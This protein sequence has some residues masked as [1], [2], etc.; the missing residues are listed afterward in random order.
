MKSASTA[1]RHDP[2]HYLRDERRLVRHGH[3][4]VEDVQGINYNR[5]VNTIYFIRESPSQPM[6]GSESA[7]AEADRGEYTND[8]VAYVSEFTTTPEG[9]WQPVAVRP[10]LAGSFIWTGFDYKG[11][12]SP[13][14]WPCINS[15]FG[16]MDICGLPKDMYYYYQAWWGNQPLGASVSALEL[17]RRAR[18]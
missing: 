7:S 1:V 14:G 5:R 18:T 13:Y 11:E 17:V 16:N 3:H 10:F 6:F 4:R 12:P 8:G 15:K 9:S 2:S